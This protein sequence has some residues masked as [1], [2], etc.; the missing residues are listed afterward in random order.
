[1]PRYFLTNR[2]TLD[3]KEIARFTQERWGHAQRVHYMRALDERLQSLAERP[4]AGRLRE[5]IG[6]GIRSGLYGPH[7]IV[8]RVLPDGIEI[9]RVLH[10]SMN[11]AARFNDDN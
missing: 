4:A 6:P 8:Y 5:D 9:A 11:L 1:M 3:L 10:A 2:A 7:L